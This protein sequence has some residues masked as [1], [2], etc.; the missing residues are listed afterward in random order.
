MHNGQGQ[1]APQLGTPMVAQ[2]GPGVLYSSLRA[3][4]YYIGTFPTTI[5]IRKKFD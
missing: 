5:L 2:L 3:L 4:R 1:Q